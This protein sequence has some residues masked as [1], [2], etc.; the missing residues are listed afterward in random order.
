[1]M[2]RNVTVDIAKAIGII[3]V[4][5][6]HANFAPASPGRFF[7]MPLFFFLTGYLSS[8]NQPFKVFLT[9]KIKSLYL[10]FLICELA[11]IALHNFFYTI[12]ILENQYTL[13]SFL[14]SVL[15]VFLF[16]SSEL[17][18]AP[19]WFMTALF[20]VN[21]LSYG[22]CFFARKTHFASSW[23]LGITFLLMLLGVYSTRFQI[24]SLLWS[25]NFKEGVNVILV[26]LF[27]CYLGYVVKN[28]G[29]IRFSSLIITLVG[30][31]YLYVAKLVLHLAV[32]MRVN[33]YSN[34][35]FWLLAC[36]LG[37]YSVMY[38]AQKLSQLP[39]VSGLL[40]Y[41]GRNSLIIL[42][43]HII[44]F[45]LVGLIQVHLFNYPIDLLA[46]WRHVDATGWW[47]IL[48]VIAGVV[49]PLG[50]DFCYKYFKK[51][52]LHRSS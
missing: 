19:L 7:Y 6:G 30:V 41:V 15:H 49:V 47:S 43:L 40:A 50:L 31:L 27:F 35:I 51:G 12:G 2:N 42:F 10:P 14:S 39:N 26:A 5:M 46:G 37:I 4:V 8:F 52:V 21:M 11:F 44:S 36:F 25:Y 34:V 48:Y 38:M 28:A 13:S 32:D 22:L 29:K 18:L 45:K 23:L 9:N 20:V 24:I 3:L 16:D 1:M 33:G 17:M